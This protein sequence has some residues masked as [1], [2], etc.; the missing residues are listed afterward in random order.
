[1][2]HQSILGGAV[3]RP[4]V[5]KKREYPVK[6]AGLPAHQIRNRVAGFFMALPFLML[7]L[8]LQ[9]QEYDGAS[10]PAATR[11]IFEKLGIPQD[12]AMV[13]L[14]NLH[15]RRN[16]Q[17]GQAQGYRI[18]IFFS[19]AL[20]AR[21]NAQKHKMNF[22]S[23]YPGHNVYVSYV[24]PDFK[25][26]VGDFRTRN[27]ALRFMKEIQPRFPR[28]FIVPDLIELPKSD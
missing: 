17:G 5:G 15:I 9:A 10:R 11:D 8:P 21:Q 12:P 16:L 4:P 22:L 27:E 24:S 1:M 19:S 7:L 6:G 3:F 25:V 20:D 14:V 18:E 28:A 26:R 13:D 2:R 23:A